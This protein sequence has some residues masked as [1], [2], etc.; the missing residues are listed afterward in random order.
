MRAVDKLLIESSTSDGTT[1]WLVLDATAQS[2]LEDVL[3]EISNEQHLFDI[4]LGCGA[5]N[6]KAL[7]QFRLF[8]HQSAAMQLA[9][10]RIDEKKVREPVVPS[11]PPVQ[12][13][14][15]V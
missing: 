4:V 3:V 9:Q 8:T 15:D 7:A 5:G 14:L 2:E 13:E 1:L 10:A 12:G 6:P 11:G